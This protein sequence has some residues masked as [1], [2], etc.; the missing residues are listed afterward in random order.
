[1]T[2]SCFSFVLLAYRT[3]ETE[4]REPIKLTGLLA[5]MSAE[6]GRADT[7]TCRVTGQ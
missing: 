2:Y 1:M 5:H 7:M 6:L 3:S 4:I